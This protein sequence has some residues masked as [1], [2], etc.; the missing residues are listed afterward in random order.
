MV[1]L[2]NT[3]NTNTLS[4]NEKYRILGDEMYEMHSFISNT[5]LDEYS[6]SIG[7]DI[8]TKKSDELPVGELTYVDFTHKIKK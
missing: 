5:T 6:K 1:F 2:S 4:E 8:D 7:C 3:I